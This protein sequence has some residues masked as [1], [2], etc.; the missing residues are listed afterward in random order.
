MMGSFPCLQCPAKLARK[1]DLSQHM[2]IHTDKFKCHICGKRNSRSSGL[3][4]H[5]SKKHGGAPNEPTPGAGPAQKFDA[6]PPLA[7]RANQLGPQAV[8]TGPSAAHKQPLSLF[9]RLEKVRNEFVYLYLYLYLNL[10]LYLYLY[11]C[12]GEERRER[13]G[14]IQRLS[15]LKEDFYSLISNL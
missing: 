5:I 14:R 12:E 7:A 6:S 15:G 3:M 13:S 10:Y 9:E 11:L 1:S 8:A 4:E 2:N